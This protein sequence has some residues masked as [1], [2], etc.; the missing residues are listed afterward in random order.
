MNNFTK[1]AS[2]ELAELEAAERGAAWGQQEADLMLEAVENGH[3]REPAAWTT[4]QWSGSNP[5]SRTEDATADLAN[6]YE[7]IIDRAAKAA[8]NA[9]IEAAGAVL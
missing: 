6:E 1:W 9:A 2:A 7:A 4:G 5:Y 3:L 8:Y